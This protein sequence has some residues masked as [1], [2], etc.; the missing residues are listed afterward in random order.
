MLLQRFTIRVCHALLWFPL[1][2][3]PACSAKVSPDLS[4]LLH[5][6]DSGHVLRLFPR[7]RVRLT[8]Y[9]IPN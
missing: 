3:G 6:V 7:I 8:T 1:T 5:Q 4:L 9:I 2:S